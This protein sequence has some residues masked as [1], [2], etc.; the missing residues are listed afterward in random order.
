MALMHTDFFLLLQPDIIVLL[1]P[2]FL[3]ILIY[4]IVFNTCS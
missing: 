2:R 4:F 1:R 3:L